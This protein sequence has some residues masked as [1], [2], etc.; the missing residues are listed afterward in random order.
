MRVERLCE[1]V[2]VWQ[3]PVRLTHWVTVLAILVLSGTGFYIGNP[4][5]GGS[6]YLMS[7]VRAIHRV[8]AYVLTA[9]LALRLYWAFR[10]N[11]WASWR[12]FVPYLTREGRRG[13]GRTF[14]YYTF[15]RR[16]PPGDIGHNPLASTVYSLVFL[17]MLVEVLT[18]F[19]LF[20]LAKGGW[21]GVAFGWVFWLGSA[22]GV[23]LVHHLVMWLLLGFTVHHVYSS[24][25]M[26][27]EERNGLMGSIFSG[28]KFSG[29]RA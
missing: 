5:I 9:S 2:Y 23:R 19:A 29:R 14:L 28:Y 8:T 15:V 20:S 3:V 17:L 24:I 4:I 12:V 11:R 26:D 22:Q 7:W 13:M 21:W 25:L 18:G 1:R 10:G 27:A 16:Q 6:V